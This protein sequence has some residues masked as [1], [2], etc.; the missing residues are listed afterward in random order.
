[1]PR[2]LKERL[3]DLRSPFALVVIVL[4]GTT[5]RW[6]GLDHLLPHR[7][8]PDSAMAW[9]SNLLHEGRGW[10]PQQAELSKYPI[11]LPLLAAGLPGPSNDPP[12]RGA[13]LDGHLSAASAPFVRV[14]RIVA[15]LAVLAPAASFP[16][17][18]LFLPVGWSLVVAGW[19]ATSLLLVLFASQARGHGAMASVT[20]LATLAAVALRRRPTRARYA[21]AGLA[22]GLALGTL[23]SGAAVLP[24]LLAAHGLRERRSE[25]AHGGL[26]IGAAVL[27]ACVAGF[28]FPLYRGLL[29]GRGMSFD[30]GTLVQG[31]HV[32]HLSSF[33]GS[34]F[35][36][37]L[38]YFWSYEPAL[39]VAAAIGLPA[40]LVRSMRRGAIDADRVVV[41]AFVLPYL[42][43]TGLYALT[44]ARFLTPLVPYLALL[45]AA[46]VRA[47]AG[48]RG[49]GATRAA[50][51]SIAALAFP[52]LVATR[53]AWLRQ[54]PDTFEQAAA[55]LTEHVQDGDS[56]VLSTGLGLPL[57]MSAASLE[58]S[59]QRRMVWRPG[60]IHYQA[61]FCKRVEPPFEV[62]ALPWDM[63]ISKR[64]DL[65]AKLLRKR[66]DEDSPT[67]LAIQVDSNRLDRMTGIVQREAAQA[68]GEVVVRFPQD[69][70]AIGRPPL[71]HQELDPAA[72]R[73][74]TEPALG[75]TVEVYRKRSVPPPGN[76]D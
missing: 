33:D 12:A 55:W 28:Y 58:E 66:L 24:A 75:S 52:T 10:K 5:L 22:G 67:F 73:V 56:V 9:Q 53:L 60:W 3:L 43:L 71:G 47:L 13:P 61:A 49:G 25:P 48:W 74:L 62:R 45:A 8:E 19:T 54:A 29:S 11:L 17:A 70:A 38:A 14:R 68:W 21:L 7:P 42:L 36:R 20:L 27:L 16:L 37:L 69:L 46:G 18:R 31:G 76:G 44:Y 15:G 41:L 30:D 59:G 65:Y 35:A 64:P 4:V 1:M 72:W 51:A 50:V 2:S 26:A 57:A 23:H 6:V 39:V 34:G 32:I 40:V 63:E